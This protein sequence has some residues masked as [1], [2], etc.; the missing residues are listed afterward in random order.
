MLLQSSNH[1]Q[2]WAKLTPTNPSFPKILLTSP[3]Y[4]IG[5]NQN[6]EIQISQ[7]HLFSS[8]CTIYK[9]PAENSIWIEPLKPLGAFWEDECLEQGIAKKLQSGDRIHL[10]YLENGMEDLVTYIFSSV[11]TETKSQDLEKLKQSVQNE[12]EC[13]IC[14]E[15]LYPCLTLLPCMHN[16]CNTCVDDISKKGKECPQCRQEFTE[17]KK[18][19]MLNNLIEGIMNSDPDIRKSCGKYKHKTGIYQIQPMGRIYLPDLGG[20]YEGEHRDG[21]PEGIGKFTSGEGDIYQG[22]WKNGKKE[23]KGKMIYHYGT[24]YEGEWKEDEYEGKGKYIYMNDEIYEGEWRKS[25]QNGQGK[26]VYAKGEMYE[27]GWRNGLKDGQGRHIYSNGD[28]YDGEWKKGVF[29]GKGEYSYSNGDIYE[30]QWKNGERDGHGKLLY[31]NG[32]VYEGEWKKNLREGKGKLSNG[33]R[34]LYVG[35]WKKD[36]MKVSLLKSL[37][38]KKAVALVN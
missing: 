4:F 36:H 16:F 32:D 19:L 5:F 27:G 31:G 3:S 11:A 1:S 26:Y 10:N 6:L 34:V 29:E 20:Y 24:V 12:L 9:D 15:Y 14:M 13:P 28:I 33:N 22:E 7:V 35:K 18:N 23:G 25:K 17:T 38:P 8:L 2:P 30:G 21:L 37:K